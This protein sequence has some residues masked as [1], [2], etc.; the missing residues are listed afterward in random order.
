LIDQFPVA[1]RDG[2]PVDEDPLAVLTDKQDT[3]VMALP[4]SAISAGEWTLFRI[5]C[6]RQLRVATHELGPVGI[7]VGRLATWMAVVAVRLRRRC[8][9]GRLD[10]DGTI[11]VH[12]ETPMGDVVVVSAPVGHLAAG[13]FVEPAEL[14]GMPAVD[15]PAVAATPLHIIGLG[16]R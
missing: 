10:G 4:A 12:A 8:C 2:S 3:V 5:W 9:A 7:G 16:S 15:E 14:I 1:G 6:T 13:I 11:A